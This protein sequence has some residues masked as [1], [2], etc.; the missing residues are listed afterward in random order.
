MSSNIFPKECELFI[1]HQ[2]LQYKPT[3]VHTFNPSTKDTEAGESE[4]KISLYSERAEL[5]SETLSQ[6]NK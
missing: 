2:K 5:Q 6:T 4:F 3:I 1:K